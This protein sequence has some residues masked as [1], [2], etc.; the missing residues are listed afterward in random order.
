MGEANIEEE[1]WN[2]FT[3]YTLHGNP[4]DPE[5]IRASQFVKLTRDCQII[6]TTLS[7]AEI[8]LTEADINV[9]YTAEVTRAD[10]IAGKGSDRK[11]MNYNDFLTVLMKLAVRVY[12]R[13]RTVDDA[14]QRLLMDNILPLASRRRPD[15]VDMFIMND[16]VNR[17]FDYYREALEQI[18]A[19]YATSDKRT[20]AAMIAANNASS[21]R[22]SNS[23]MLGYSG[24]SPGRATKAVNSMK[25]ALGY[26]EF[27]K[28]ASDFDLSNSVILSTIELGDI[29]LSSIKAVEPDSTI[30]KLT[31]LEFWE[32]LVRCAL[33]AYSKISDTTILDKIRGLFLYM[34]RSINKSVPRAFTD[35]RNVSTYAG[36]LL[37]GAMLFNKRFTAAWAQDNY[38]D[39]LSPDP[40]VLETGKTVLNRVAKQLQGN[41]STNSFYRSSSSIS[42]TLMNDNNNIDNNN[43]IDNSNNYG[44]DNNTDNNNNIPTSSTTTNTNNNQNNGV[45]FGYGGY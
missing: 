33:V 28:F 26:Q 18:F 6:G 45:Y 27:L 11:K 12:P 20:T 37:S 30:R 3:Y 1:L 36:D 38:R 42:N 17:L 31:F 35:R 34:W 5:H 2:I 19:F 29:Y 4:L 10:K 23:S 25:G 13:A 8:P 41:S 9:A 40:R 24:R 32:T 14:F 15:A 43:D 22:I 21:S 7:E 44:Y 39:Y 16:D